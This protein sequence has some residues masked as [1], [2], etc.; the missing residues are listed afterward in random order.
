MLILSM[1]VNGYTQDFLND[2]YAVDLEMRVWIHINDQ[3]AGVFC[4]FGMIGVN[5][6][7]LLDVN[8][9]VDY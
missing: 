5:K 2:S 4:G 8:L 7:Y 6:G 1:I 9:S 3:C